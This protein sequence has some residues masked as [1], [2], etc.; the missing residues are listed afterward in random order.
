MRVAMTVE[1]S[2]HVVPGGIAT[3]TV[4][5]LRALAGRPDVDVVG[6]AARH[7]EPPADAFTVPAPVRQLPMP[8]R[9]LYEAWQWLRWPSVE[10]ATGPVDVTHDMGYVVP[11]SRAPLVATVHDLWFLE[12]PDHYTRHTALV[13]KR[14]FEL[15]RRDARLVMCPSRSTMDAC[16]AAGIEPDRLRQVPW[17]VRTRAIERDEAR[18][19]VRRL[20][21]DRPYVLYT[22]TIERRKNIPRLVAAFE[23]VGRDDVDLVLAGPRG[24]APDAW[25]RGFDA[26]IARLGSRCRLLGDVPPRELDALCAR[27]EVV[28][29][30]S[31]GEGFGFPIL[32]AMAQGA[33]VVTSSGTSTEE[34]AGDAAMLADPTDVD[35]IAGVIGRVLDDRGLTAARAELGRQRAQTFTWERSADLV[36]DVYRE[37]AS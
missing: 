1:Q 17:G 8:R 3:S 2:W 6:V 37:A 14:G 31:L 27:A 36:V 35:A 15:A 30:P 18:A 4:E 32:Y 22:G 20:G 13:L 24:W 10:R 11:P 29:Y 12:H 28:A 16:E 23:R 25:W 26:A 7:R 33:P 34:I 19:I 9:V 21:L 5:L